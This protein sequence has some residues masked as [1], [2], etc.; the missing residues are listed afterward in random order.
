MIPGE[1]IRRDEPIIIN[2]GLP[3]TTIDITN[4]SPLP[5]HIT[6]HFHVFEAN[7]CLAFDRLAAWGMRLD[8]PS[9]GAVRFEPGATVSVNLVP[10]GGDRN[11][12]GFQGVVNG[13]LDQ[14]DPAEALARLIERGFQHVPKDE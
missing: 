14:S 7:P 10:I 2:A 11:V 9:D 1:I 3:V 13:S 4:T 8:V 6:A 12:Y 5:V